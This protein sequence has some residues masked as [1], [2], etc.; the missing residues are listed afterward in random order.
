MLTKTYPQLYCDTRLGGKPHW[1]I[2][3]CEDINMRVPDEVLECVCFLCVN[4]RGTYKYGGT[5]FFITIPSEKHTNIKYVYIVTAKHCVERAKQYGALYLRL[6]TLN[7]KAEMIEVKR[8][9]FYPLDESSDVAVLPF[10]PP[11]NI[12]RYGYLDMELFATEEVIKEQRIGVGDDLVITG[13][14]TKRF[15]NQRNIPIVRTGIIAAMPEEA[16]EDENTGLEYNAYL[17]EVRSIGGLSGSPVFVWL[18]AGRFYQ[19]KITMSH[20][21]FLLGLVRGHWD[22]QHRGHPVDFTVEESQAVNVGIAII[23]PI[24]EILDIIYGEELVKARRLEDRERSKAIA[25]V[26][27]TEYTES[28]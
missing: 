1:L 16:L 18:G 23:T 14:F 3:Q 22:I 27:D 5:G 12:F 17:A 25:P 8:D 7:G 21:V 4:D 20:K 13:L 15:G 9:W 24:Y 10:V 11:Q 19:N 6:N 26:K 28:K 2:G